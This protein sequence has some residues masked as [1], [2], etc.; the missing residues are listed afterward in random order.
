[1]SKTQEFNPKIRAD[2]RIRRLAKQKRWSDV[3]PS[4]MYDQDMGAIM[5][6]YY[7]ALRITR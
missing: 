3:R 5:S 7:Q 2:S 6:R 4:E 1:M